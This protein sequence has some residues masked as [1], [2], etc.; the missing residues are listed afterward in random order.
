MSYNPLRRFFH[1]F[2]FVRTILLVSQLWCINF[3]S[4]TRELLL[5]TLIPAK[6][7]KSRCTKGIVE[8]AIARIYN[9]MSDI[10]LRCCFFTISLSFSCRECSQVKYVNILLI[11][12]FQSATFHPASSIFSQ[13]VD[14]TDRNM[15]FLTCN[16]SFFFLSTTVCLCRSHD[17]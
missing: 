9:L 13:E 6:F 8:F 16:I 7:S 10:G 12:C 3:F 5:V 1:I 2:R 15:N 14:P 4:F 11:V 17:I